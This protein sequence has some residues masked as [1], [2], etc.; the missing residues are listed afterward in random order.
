LVQICD[1]T[2]LL[3]FMGFSIVTEDLSFFF[4]R[5]VLAAALVTVAAFRPKRRVLSPLLS[6]VTGVM[7]VF[8]LATKTTR[9]N[10][11]R[12]S[13]PPFFLFSVPAIQTHPPPPYPLSLQFIHFRGWVFKEFP[14]HNGDSNTF[15]PSLHVRLP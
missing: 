15:S 11:H 7:G 4:L 6:E 1:E 14:P 5:E 10:H 2:F 13:R 9:S 8:T 12:L 3:C